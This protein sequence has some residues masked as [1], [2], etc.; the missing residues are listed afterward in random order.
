METSLIAI[1]KYCFYYKLLD[2]EQLKTRCTL[3]LEHVPLN[4][5]LTTKGRK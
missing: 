4:M 5:Q 2:N 1:G 3:R